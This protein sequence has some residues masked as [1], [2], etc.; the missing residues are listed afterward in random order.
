MV[1]RSMVAGLTPMAFAASMRFNASFGGPPSALSVVITSQQCH[2]MNPMNTDS[3]PLEV[4]ELFRFL[5]PSWLAVSKADP[6]ANLLDPFK[7][8]HAVR[9]KLFYKHLM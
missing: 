3:E 1:R 9:T 8:T 7:F 6:L 5:R 4:S 2:D